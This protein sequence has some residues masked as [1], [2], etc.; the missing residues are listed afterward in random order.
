MT[1]KPFLYAVSSGLPQAWYNLGTHYFS[2]RG[3]EQ[4][5]KQAAHFFTL[6]AEA[7]MVQAMVRG[8]QIRT[9]PRPRDRG[10]RVSIQADTCC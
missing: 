6:A 10:T 7:G 1:L 8:I 5:L 4:D 3:V 9:S 2:G